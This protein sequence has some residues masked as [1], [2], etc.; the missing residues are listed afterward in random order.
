MVTSK[1]LYSRAEENDLQFAK[2]L[3]KN[4]QGAEQAEKGFRDERFVKIEPLQ[5]NQTIYMGPINKAIRIVSTLMQYLS[6]EL[7]FP[8]DG[9]CDV[10]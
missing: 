4:T 6:S 10:P 7:S 8:L 9:L 5:E 3:E 2:E 1:R